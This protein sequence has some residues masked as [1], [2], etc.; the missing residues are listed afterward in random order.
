[1]RINILYGDKEYKNHHPTRFMDREGIK[2]SIRKVSVAVYVPLT[3]TVLA[4]LPET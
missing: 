1:M 3:A 2:P 4:E